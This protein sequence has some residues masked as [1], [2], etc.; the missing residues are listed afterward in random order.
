MWDSRLRDPHVS[1]GSSLLPLTHHVTV[2]RGEKTGGQQCMRRGKSVEQVLLVVACTLL[3]VACMHR[4]DSP[5]GVGTC[6]MCPGL[7]A[8]EVVVLGAKTLAGLWVA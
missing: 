7:H 5:V 4:G 6:L 8:R 2:P 3:V 1:P